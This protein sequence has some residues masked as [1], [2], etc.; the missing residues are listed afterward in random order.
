M[1]GAPRWAMA[2]AKLSAMPELASQYVT[3]LT[4]PPALAHACHDATSRL[5]EELRAPSALLEHIDLTLLD[6]RDAID[7][8]GDNLPRHGAAN[9]RPSSSGSASAALSLITGLTAQAPSDTCAPCI[10]RAF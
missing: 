1:L 9:S 2:R 5:A 8:L 4:P 3:Y 10:S 6:E 7:Q